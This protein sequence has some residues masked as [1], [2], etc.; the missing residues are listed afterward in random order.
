MIYYKKNKKKIVIPSGLNCGEGCSESCKLQEGSLALG[1]DWSGP[2]TILPDLDHNGFSKFVVFDNG[3]GA[4]KYQEGYDAGLEAC[5]GTCNLT[6]GTINLQDGDS[7]R[8]NIYPDEGYDGF[9]QVL[10]VDQGYGQ[11]KYNAGF[12]AAKNCERYYMQVYYNKRDADSYGFEIKINGVVVANANNMYFTPSGWKMYEFTELLPHIDTITTV[13]LKM[14]LHKPLQQTPPDAISYFRIN[15]VDFNAANQTREYVGDDELFEYWNFH[16][17]GYL[18]D[19]PKIDDGKI[20]SLCVKINDVSAFNDGVSQISVRGTTTIGT[21]QTYSPSSIG[22]H[23]ASVNNNVLTIASNF[24]LP[25]FNLISGD[26][27]QFLKPI[28]IGLRISNE[29]A[30]YFGDWSIDE[31][32]INGYTFP[33]GTYVGGQR[34]TVDDYI[35]SEDGSYKT[36]AINLY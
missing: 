29:D 19:I 5:G 6:A 26:Q 1:E 2:E 32:L 25:Q 35:L 34:L 16:L 22:N 10:I 14:K 36:I 20:K 7:G 15:G 17:V 3:Y 18:A 12:E 11:G 27:S 24:T 21:S 33:D 23:S 31:V 9:D 4:E 8:W 30:A 13:D 28:F